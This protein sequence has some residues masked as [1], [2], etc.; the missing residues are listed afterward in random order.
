MIK[1]ISMIPSKSH[2]QMIVLEI[3]SPAKNIQI[4]ETSSI[5]KTIK[6]HKSAGMLKRILPREKAIDLNNKEMSGR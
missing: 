4:A 6:S 5:S 3:R 1:M 2:A